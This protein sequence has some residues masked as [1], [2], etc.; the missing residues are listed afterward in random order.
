MKPKYNKENL[1][2]LQNR[3]TE[4]KETNIGEMSSEENHATDESEA[5]PVCF[6]YICYMN[7]YLFV[8]VLFN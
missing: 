1:L 6:F 5:K 8:C 7:K 4:N 3:K 2:F